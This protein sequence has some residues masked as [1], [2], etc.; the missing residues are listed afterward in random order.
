MFSERDYAEKLPVPA[1]A[2]L[3]LRCRRS[4]ADKIMRSRFS[5]VAKGALEKERSPAAMSDQDRKKIQVVMV[6]C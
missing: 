4:K 3:W 1:E 5:S 2:P 6:D